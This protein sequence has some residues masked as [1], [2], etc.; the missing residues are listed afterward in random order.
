MFSRLLFASVLLLVQITL[1]ACGARSTSADL[2]LKTKAYDKWG[3][4]WVGESYDVDGDGDA[5]ELVRARENRSPAVTNPATGEVLIAEFYDYQLIYGSC[6][7]PD[8]SSACP[9]PLSVVVRGPCFPFPLSDVAKKDEI[10]IRGVDGYVK[11]D[12]GLYINTGDFTLI[13][14]AVG[15]TEEE[16]TKRALKVAKDLGRRQRQGETHSEGRRLQAEGRRCLP[17]CADADSAP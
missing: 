13:V 4:V 8:G 2:G 9:V 15:P 5:E 17:A 7:I 1:I 3:V 12:G 10:R 14:D 6:A 16:S 11:Q